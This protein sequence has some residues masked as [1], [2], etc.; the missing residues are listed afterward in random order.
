MCVER[1][2]VF[3]AFAC[4]PHSFCL[5]IPANMAE[6]EVAKLLVGNDSG[7]CK[8]GFVGD[9]SRMFSLIKNEN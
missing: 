8:V 6:E 4:C 7:M 3:V 1:G 9:V 5:F 2:L